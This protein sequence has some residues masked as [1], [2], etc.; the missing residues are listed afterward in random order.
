MFKKVIAGARLAGLHRDYLQQLAHAESPMQ[1]ALLARK[2]RLQTT[3]IYLRLVGRSPD[4][5]DSANLATNKFWCAQGFFLINWLAKEGVMTAL[6]AGGLLPEAMTAAAPLHK[7]TIVR[8]FANMQQIFRGSGTEKQQQL[9]QLFEDSYFEHL[10]DS[11]V[12]MDASSATIEM[13][14]KPEL[15]IECEDAIALINRALLA[16]KKIVCMNACNTQ[17]LGSAPYKKG[18]WE[19]AFARQTDMAIQIIKHFQDITQMLQTKDQL[20]VGVDATRQEALNVDDYKAQYLA[21]L[22]ELIV[23]LLENPNLPLTAGFYDKLFA[24]PIYMT[25]QNSVYEIDPDWS[26]VDHGLE[27]NFLPES[28]KQ[29]HCLQDL[30]AADGMLCCLQED[31]FDKIVFAEVAAPDLRQTASQ[32]SLRGW[33]APYDAL[34]SLND[35][36]RNIRDPQVADKILRA[37]IQNTLDL[38][39]HTDADV[40]VINGFGCGAFGHQPATVAEIYCE[41]LSARVE[42]LQNKQICFVDINAKTAAQ[43]AAVF[44]KLKKTFLI[45]PSHFENGAQLSVLFNT[46][47]MENIA[48]T[49]ETRQKVGIG[50]SHARSS[51]VP[52][53]FRSTQ[54]HV[55]SQEFG[56][57]FAIHEW[58]VFPPT[59]TPIAIVQLR[60]AMLP[61]NYYFILAALKPSLDG[62]TDAYL[63]IFQ[64]AQ[65]QGI[66]QLQLPLLGSG[67]YGVD[68]RSCLQALKTA[69]MN[70]ENQDHEFK[71]QVELHIIGEHVE[72]CLPELKPQFS[73]ASLQVAAG[74]QPVYCLK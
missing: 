55:L 40:I 16:G 28:A 3:M 70:W 7:E 12:R 61:S 10:A 52:T 14:T 23:A 2:T 59:T 69:L 13:Q 49:A 45:N 21:W 1:Q 25:M 35:N 65:H 54:Q 47:G 34:A 15:F 29:Y 73:K 74:E 50:I 53:L 36:W 19:E 72:I 5:N 66:S 44:S 68:A 27:V 9:L 22:L 18:T 64:A 58:N 67:K 31:P 30:F 42:S 20:V 48:L 11:S 24:N 8:V 63:G 60:G 37:G 57:E 32:L 71:L 62:L 46:L 26:V 33:E 17:R 4:P 51:H 39:I 56:Q 38:G 41:E 43:F 6:H